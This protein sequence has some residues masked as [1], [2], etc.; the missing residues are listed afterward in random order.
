MV[1]KPQFMSNFNQRI[2]N[3]ELKKDIA[4]NNGPRFSD[5]VE[6][7]EIMYFDLQFSNYS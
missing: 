4:P 5:G 2:L 7:Y 3:H 1:D 6:H